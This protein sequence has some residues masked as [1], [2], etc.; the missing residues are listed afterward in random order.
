M[1]FAISQS[2]EIASFV[3]QIVQN[4]PKLFIYVIN[5]REMHQFL[6]FKKLEPTN[7]IHFAWKMKLLTDSQII[8]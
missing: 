5:V 8:D 4:P 7:I 1:L 2:P 6:A 3:Q